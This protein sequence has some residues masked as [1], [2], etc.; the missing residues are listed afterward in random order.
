MLY[1]GRISFRVLCYYTSVGYPL[2]FGKVSSVGRQSLYIF[3]ILKVLPNK[4]IS[5]DACQPFSISVPKIYE[6]QPYFCN[7]K[8]PHPNFHTEPSAHA[9]LHSREPPPS[10][11]LIPLHWSSPNHCCLFLDF[12]K[13]LLS[14]WKNSDF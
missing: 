5:V 10:K 12:K 3:Y 4:M 6:P 2:G 14:Q 13:N 1:F 7:Q 11:W 8:S 9:P